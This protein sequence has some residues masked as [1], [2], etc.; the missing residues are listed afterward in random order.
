MIL[1][2]I[3]T[4]YYLG[5]SVTS[6]QPVSNDPSDP[7][8]LNEKPCKHQQY[9]FRIALAQGVLIRISL[10]FAEPTTVLAI[11]I[12]R[13]TNNDLLVGVAGSI[14]TAGW[15]LPQLLV[16]NLI[17]H[18]PRKMPYYIIGM[19]CRVTVWALICGAAYLIPVENS[20][21]L[22]TVVLALYFCASFSMGVS[23]L[24]Y[25]DII[26]KSI[27][28]NRRA[29]FFSWRQLLGRFFEFLI[30]YFLIAYV[31]DQEKSG[32]IFPH[33]YALLF[34]CTTIASLC[35][36]LVFLK[37]REPIL[38]VRTERLSILDHLRK[39][40]Q[41][42]KTDP[43]YRRFLSFRIC[44]HFVGASTPFYATYALEIFPGVTESTA[45]HFLATAAVT[46]IISNVFWR[47]LGERFGTR[48]I[49]VV[50]GGLIGIPP[51][52]AL[53][54]S[55][56]PVDQQLNYYFLVYAIGGVSSNGIMVGFM[57][58]ALNIAPGQSRPT[59][60]GF[61]NTLL[62]PFAFVPLIGGASLRFLSPWITIH[63]LFLVSA[64]SGIL[65][66]LMALR[67]EEVVRENED[68]LEDL[69]TDKSRS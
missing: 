38:P 46:G 19:A 26:S 15:M 62:F 50:T 60:I 1:V 68:P 43:H 22:A 12:K 67:L 64:I 9:N 57:T 65:S 14:M 2:I 42:L 20:I 23:T 47:Y 8:N 48:S 41:I 40:P 66:F 63:H 30:G 5:A 55:L 69:I 39:G 6:M 49:L 25:M 24:P 18:H 59:Y 27:P 58:Y 37:I 16:S 7:S 36:F 45:G 13:L 3:G 21:L 28:P 52:I 51:L 4:P 29:R 11:F 10:A 53:T 34:A 32:L 54:S 35:A 44:G 33:N 61:M 31:L 56:M 17:E